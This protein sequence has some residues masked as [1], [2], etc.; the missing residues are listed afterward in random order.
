VIVGE[1]GAAALY[2]WRDRFAAPWSEVGLRVRP[3]QQPNP[4]LHLLDAT[5]AA[6]AEGQILTVAAVAYRIAQIDLPRGGLTRL[7]LTPDTAT[8]DEDARWK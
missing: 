7:E 5:A 3:S 6:L 1:I 8:P 2:G 4:A